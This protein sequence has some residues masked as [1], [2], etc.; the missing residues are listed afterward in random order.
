MF[1]VAVNRF[2]FSGPGAEYN[3]QYLILKMSESLKQL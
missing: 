1:L 2:I 3:V